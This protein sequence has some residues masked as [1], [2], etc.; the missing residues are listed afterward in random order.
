MSHEREYADRQD[1]KLKQLRIK[2]LVYDIDTEEQIREHDV[3]FSDGDKR[4]WLSQL[5]VWAASNKK[6]VEII[7]YFDD[8]N[9]S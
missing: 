4:R 8:R 5:I 6:S 3:N 7:N 1:R 2:V 9:I